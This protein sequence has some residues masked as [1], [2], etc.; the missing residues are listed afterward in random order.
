VSV[1]S[2]SCIIPATNI[3]RV[4]DDGLAEETPLRLS[5]H[6]AHADA[7]NMGNQPT[8]TPPTM[9]YQHR[10]TH[11]SLLRN[12]LVGSSSKTLVNLHIRFAFI[13]QFEPT[14]SSYM[15]NFTGF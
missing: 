15:A 11:R 13:F 7:P 2:A 10:H 12:I 8:Q 6:L 4:C 5:T 9:D 3:S 1:S 14:L